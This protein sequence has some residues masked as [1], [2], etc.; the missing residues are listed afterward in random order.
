[1]YEFSVHAARRLEETNYSGKRIVDLGA[2][3]GL[4]SLQLALNGGDV[5]S[6]D[7]ACVVENLRD[8]MDANL[9]RMDEHMRSTV[10]EKRGTIK[11]VELDWEQAAQREQVAREHGPFDLI[12]A[13][14]CLYNVESVAPLFD[15]IHELAAAGNPEILFGGIVGDTT[16]AAVEELITARGIEVTPMDQERDGGAILCQPITTSLQ[17]AGKSANLFRLRFPTKFTPKSGPSQS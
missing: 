7:L 8:N 9:R 5:I 10:A 17:R 14:G 12:A 6:T 3:C 11:V 1:M 15:T 4:L 2:G 16:L 13:I